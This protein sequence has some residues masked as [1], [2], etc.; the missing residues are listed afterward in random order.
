MDR[1]EVTNAE[2][3][4][5]LNAMETHT[6]GKRSAIKFYLDDKRIKRVD[7]G[8]MVEHRVAQGYENHPVHGV[9]W[10][11]ALAYATW[12][13]K[14]LPT[15]A[16]WEKAARGGLIGM[17]YPWGDTIDLHQANYNPNVN[18]NVGK[19]TPIG[20]Y[21]ANG[22]GLYDMAG[23][24]LEWCLDEYNSGFYA[25]S[26]DKNPIAGGSI[27]SI[28][29]NFT[30]VKTKRVLRGGSCFDALQFM[31]CAS[32]F[33][34]LPSGNFYRLGFRCVKAVPPPSTD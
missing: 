27:T 19:T 22:Y 28:I 14:R 20:S 6:E 5:F 7:T 23:N 32:R 30:K 18:E 25:N 11:G 13:G 1:Y 26:P 24:V 12:V 29:K 33:Y 9:T 21:P 16:E 2:Y 31:R 10:Y 34:G 3:V 4:A 8:Y 15:E 17:A